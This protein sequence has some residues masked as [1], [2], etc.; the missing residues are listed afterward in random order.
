MRSVTVTLTLST[1]VRSFS[2]RIWIQ[3][4]NRRDP[5][6]HPVDVERSAATVKQVVW[7]SY[8]ATDLQKSAKHLSCRS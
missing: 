8:T 7:S 6:E 4:V 3:R 1:M 5:Y 2:F